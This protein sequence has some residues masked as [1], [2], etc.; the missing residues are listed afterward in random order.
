MELWHPFCEKKKVG[1][2]GSFVGGPY[3]GI[4]HTTE[5]KTIEGALGLA[6]TIAP[7]FMIG[8][9]SKGGIRLIQFLPLN[10]AGKTAKNA[11]GGVETNRRSAIQ[12][13][14]VG[15]ADPRLPWGNSYVGKWN[16]TYLDAIAHLMRWIE[17]QTGIKRYAPANWVAYPASYGVR[18][19]QRMSPVAWNDFNGW[20]GHQ[21]VPEN[22]HGDPG[23]LNINYLL[24]RFV[25]APPATPPTSTTR[26]KG[27]RMLSISNPANPSPKPGQHPYLRLS[28]DGKTL[29]SFFSEAFQKVPGVTS[30]YGGQVLALPRVATDIAKDTLTGRIIIRYTDNTTTHLPLQPGVTV[31]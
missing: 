28:D 5:G 12:I 19:P 30:V 4:L 17:T 9:S 21:H 7:H 6:S 26:P 15:T 3:R 10:R 11:P 16:A 20:C 29:I 25:N 1:D 23:A 13:E 27:R 24:T 18:A 14:M 8:P 22:D 31:G 2:A